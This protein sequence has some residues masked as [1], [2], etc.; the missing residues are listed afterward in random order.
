MIFNWSD[1]DIQNNIVYFKFDY[2]GENWLFSTLNKEVALINISKPWHK[3]YFLE[4]NP[5]N[6]LFEID[7]TLFS[8]SVSIVNK[9]I[10]M[11]YKN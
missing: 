9:E 10:N 2:N 8:A 5:N 4:F 11:E 6:E 1:R 3:T 7:T